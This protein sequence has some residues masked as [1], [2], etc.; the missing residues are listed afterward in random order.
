MELGQATSD[1]ARH[2][3][4]SV[5]CNSAFVFFFVPTKGEEMCLLVQDELQPLSQEVPQGNTTK[6]SIV[7]Q[8]THLS[9][10]FGIKP[11]SGTFLVSW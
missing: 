7:A 4:G 5:I 10:V 6:F 11:A 8:E 3:K 9:T 1:S 2:I